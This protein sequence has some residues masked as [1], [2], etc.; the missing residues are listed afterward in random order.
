MLL[1]SAFLLSDPFT[2]AFAHRQSHTSY[3]FV[4]NYYQFT[5]FVSVSL[6]IF[7]SIENG[8][9]SKARV[10]PAEET[11]VGPPDICCGNECVGV[12]GKAIVSV[13]Q[14]LIGF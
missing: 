4:S 3:L 13:V 5:Y 8:A 9:V 12:W 6:Y 1:A 2:T 7:I 10:C 11:T 14:R